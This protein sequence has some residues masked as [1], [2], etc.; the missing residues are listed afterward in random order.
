MADAIVH[1]TKYQAFKRD[2]ERTENSIPIRIKAYFLA[3]FHIIELVMAEEGLH[4]GQPQQVQAMLGSN[5]VVKGK[6]KQ[7]WKDF[8]QLDKIRLEEVYGPGIN[9]K[10]LKKVQRLFETI[11]KTCLEILGEES[12]LQ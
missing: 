9:G 11:E 1:R 5:A 10:N 2:A 6:T 3:A 12:F 8:Q 7:I 4:I